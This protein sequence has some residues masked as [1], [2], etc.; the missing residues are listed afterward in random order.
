[1]GRDVDVGDDAVV[2]GAEEVRGGYNPPKGPLAL[3]EH[4]HV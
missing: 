4:P 2:A 3:H 1:V